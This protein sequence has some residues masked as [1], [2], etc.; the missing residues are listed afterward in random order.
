MYVSFFCA[1]F[2]SV[3]DTNFWCFTISQTIMQTPSTNIHLAGSQQLI[4]GETFQIQKNK[5]VFQIKQ[6]IHTFSCTRKL[7]TKSP[8]QMKFREWKEIKL[9]I[10]LI[11]NTNFIHAIN[12][13]VGWAWQVSSMDRK[14]LAISVKEGRWSGSAAQHCSINLFQF[15]SHELGTGGLSVLFK[16]PTT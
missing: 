7:T 3:R 16:I 12:Q 10:R 13:T 14:Q 1:N 5:K 2:W 11:K 15:G 9:A 6:H 4:K 8:T